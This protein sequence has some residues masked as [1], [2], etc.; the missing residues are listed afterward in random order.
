MASWDSA[1]V[2]TLG[3][4]FGARRAGGFFFLAASPGGLICDGGCG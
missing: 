3:L 4:L 2:V 1:C